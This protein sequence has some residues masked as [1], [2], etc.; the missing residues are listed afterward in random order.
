MATKKR[1]YDVEKPYAAKTSLIRSERNKARRVFI[2]HH[3]EAAAEG[4]D[5]DHIR[6]LSKGGT[7]D[8][9]NLRAV[10]AKKN[11]SFAR[12]KDSSMKTTVK[13]K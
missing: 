13:K 4:K 1:N 7:N 3:G 6:P 12:N 5:I 10:P 11:R 2:K 9:K 8:I